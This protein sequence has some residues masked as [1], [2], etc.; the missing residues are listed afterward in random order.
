MATT[1]TQ[2]PER[3][4]FTKYAGKNGKFFKGEFIQL[5]PGNFQIRISE[6]VN[7]EKTV[8]ETTNQ[9]RII[10]VDKLRPGKSVKGSAARKEA[11]DLID[12]FLEENEISVLEAIKEVVT[13]GKKGQPETK[14]YL[15]EKE[16]GIEVE[17][18]LK[19]ERVNQTVEIERISNEISFK[20]VKEFPAFCRIQAFQFRK[21]FQNILN[22]ISKSK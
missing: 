17:Y 12:A 18:F 2:T 1:E 14:Q 7:G 21:A 6:Q 13:K 20:A 5:D 19:E 4:L 11:Q 8:T 15:I 22:Q 9:A 16:I 10:Q 3:I